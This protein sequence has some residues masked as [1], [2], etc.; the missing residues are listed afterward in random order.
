MK[1]IFIIVGIVGLLLYLFGAYLISRK[2]ILSMKLGKSAWVK[3][4]PHFFLLQCLGIVLIF[5][6]FFGLVPLNV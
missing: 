4:T 2:S 5:V 3:T 1:I 6:S